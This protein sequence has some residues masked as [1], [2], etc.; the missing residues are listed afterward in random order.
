MQTLR[1]STGKIESQGGQ[2]DVY[3]CQFVK[4]GLIKTAGGQLSNLE[5][6]AQALQNAVQEGK[7]EHLASFVDH[8]G[9]FENPSLGNL[10]GV[11]QDA[12]FDPADKAVVGNIRLYDTPAGR[13]MGELLGEILQD[14]ASGGAVPDVGLSIVFW[15]EWETPSQ[16]PLA[17]LS[18]S[19]AR[20]ITG[21]RHVESVDFVFQPAAEGRV[22]E[23]LST[24]FQTIGGDEMEEQELLAEPVEEMGDDQAQAWS[25]AM[26]K[27]AA[28][29]MIAAS[30]LPAASRERLSTGQF[31]TPLAVEA[32][33]EAERQYLARL[34]QDQ[35]I[36]IGG[37]APR[38]GDIQ[39]GMSSLERI[40]KAFEALMMGARPP[41][42]VQ[43]LTGIR[44]LY[45]LLSG[46]YEMTGVFQGD[47]LQ[48]ANVTSSTMSNM[49]A[50]VL[51]KVI[52]Q[53]FIQYPQW[54]IPIVNEMDFQ[55][56]QAV[57]WIT[58]GGVGELP[59]VSEGAAYTELTWDDKYETASFVKKGGYL[60]LTLEAIDKDDTTRLRS[61]PQALAQSAWL[62][63]SKG[64]SN[65]F[66][67]NSGVGPAMVDGDALFHTNHGNL[68]TTALSVTAWTAARLAMRKQTEVNSAERLGALTAPKFL[69][70]PPD[71]EV[72]GLQVLGTDRDYTYALSNGTAA[73]MNVHSEGGDLEMRM[74][75]ARER[76][77][78]VDLWTDTNNWAA[79]ADPK[80]YPTIGIG[81][82]YGRTP[83]IFSVASP[84]AGLMFS[85]DTMPIKVRFFYAV[86]PV[87]YRGLYK[88]NVA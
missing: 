63:L 35:V 87:D 34:S 18:E 69:L 8:A 42:G 72:T 61:A 75:F 1:L 60:G 32:A 29:G 82:R 77:I 39:V 52:V 22:L 88:A 71:L 66:T 14:Q 3:K 38:G 74:R 51:N 44:E 33:I 4:A 28:A 6:T 58:L 68:G 21:I 16:P 62:T 7:F 70:V 65:I 31:E 20:R 56:L 80:L 76:V 19:E 46:D 73:P 79:V 57:R 10:A 48:F 43:P 17:D 15:P 27:T 49:V 45:H 50:N 30:G 78:V 11:T 85:N 5:M 86:G 9:W 81:Y 2:R 41:A 47:R 55:S 59:T 24:I 64:V 37:M 26:A 23:K 84:T 67:Y 12:G 40:E 83:E 13:V 36:S 53:E 54:W 25:Q